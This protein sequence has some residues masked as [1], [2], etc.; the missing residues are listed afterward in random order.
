VALEA[1]SVA[2][3]AGVALGTP[4]DGEMVEALLANVELEAPF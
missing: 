4:V 2:V 3:D 1:L